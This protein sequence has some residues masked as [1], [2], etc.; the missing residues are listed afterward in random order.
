MAPLGFVYTGKFIS[1]FQTA[2]ARLLIGCATIASG[3]G[4]CYLFGSA[5][6]NS[7][8]SWD[9]SSPKTYESIIGGLL[10]GISLPGLPKAFKDGLKNTS[11]GWT[12]IKNQEH[13]RNKM[14]ELDQRLAN[15]I[16]DKVDAQVRD[17]NPKAPKPTKD[18]AICI[19]TNAEGKKFYAF[20]GPD[21]KAVFYG[22]IPPGGANADIKPKVTYSAS[23]DMPFSQV[24]A[25]LGITQE[26]VSK[27][28][29]MPIERNQTQPRPPGNCGEP[30]AMVL[31]FKA[32]NTTERILSFSTFQRTANGPIP[33]DACLNCQ[34]YVPGN[35]YT[36]SVFHNPF[37][38]SFHYVIYSVQFSMQQLHWNSS[39]ESPKKK[40]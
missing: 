31:A 33:M 26:T 5:A 19:A 2:N 30:R 23:S 25:K 21:G 17:Q 3:G 8:T 36:D 12:R 35:I 16:L 38:T 11:K 22:E 32:G 18:G 28:S 4:T 6:N 10:L 14:Y 34:Q 9:M 24:E 40:D 13:F 1:S 7:F 29:G 27:Q 37:Q 15:E 39:Q 20:S